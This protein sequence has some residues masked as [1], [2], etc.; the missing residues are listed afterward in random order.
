MRN[1]NLNQSRNNQLVNH[2]LSKRLWKG[3]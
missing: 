1:F 2:Q 3:Q